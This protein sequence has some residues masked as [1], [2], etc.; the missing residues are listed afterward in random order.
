M[1][2]SEAGLEFKKPFLLSQL[3][4]FENRSGN[5]TQGDEHTRERNSFC[6]EKLNFLY[7]LPRENTVPFACHKF[8]HRLTFPAPI[9]DEKK[10]S[11]SNTCE[12]RQHKEV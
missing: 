12:I 8:F 5:S 6:I 9:P 7:I 11:K 3:N 4:K 1:M 2:S 10:K